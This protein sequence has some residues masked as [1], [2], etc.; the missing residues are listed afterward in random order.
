ME[1]NSRH[2][3]LK[4]LQ[5]ELPRGA[6]FDLATLASL[7]VSPQLAARYAKGGWLVRLAQAVYAF[8]ND[9]FSVEGAVLFLQRHVPGLHIGGKSAL[10]LH[11]VR[12]N[13][14]RR[15]TLVLWGDARFALPTWFTT[16]FPARYAY[17][18]LFDWPDTD[19]A[20]RSLTTPPGMPDA[21][22]VSVA[23]R[24]VLELLYDVGVKEGLEEARNLFDSLRSPRKELLGQLLSCCTSVKA[25]RLFLTW[26]RETGIVDVDAMLQQHAVRTGSSARWTSRLDDGTLLILN[27]HG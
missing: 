27:P 13:L 6:P 18:R 19:L 22:R 17:A 4:R 7:G 11:G 12:H 8:P 23:E 9:D 5:A 14:H 25:V 24:A 15:D 2:Q 16:R 26:A 21:L 20:T 3:V 1:L 10:A